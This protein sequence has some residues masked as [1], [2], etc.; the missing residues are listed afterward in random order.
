MNLAILIPS[1][2]RPDVLDLTLSGLLKTVDTTVH[3][4][5]IYLGLLKTSHD[6]EHVALKH[7]NAFRG[8][9]V[10]FQ[11][12]TYSDNIGKAACLNDLLK[13]HS[14]GP[15]YVITMDNDMVLTGQWYHIIEAAI[16]YGDFD[17][18]GFA[19]TRF[20]AHI[21]DREHSEFEERN[22][23][24]FYDCP[25]GIAGGMMLFKTQYLL[26]HPW[27]NH[28]GV[29]GRDDATMCLTTSLKRVVYWESDWLVHD[30]IA[31]MTPDLKRYQ[32]AKEDLYKRGITVF[33]EGWDEK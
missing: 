30:P 15:E 22:G 21:P 18:M 29:Y 25:S 12:H 20:W 23:Y 4:T 10:D 32:D 16:A 26:D 8:V 28:G 6:V 13:R 19:S 7:E 17:L 2:K 14:N 11:Y 3:Q 33:P 9:G 5:G 27:T 24:R 1:Y 31:R